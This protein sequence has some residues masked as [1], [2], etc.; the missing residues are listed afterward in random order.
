M[1]KGTDNPSTE[2]DGLKPQNVVQAAKEDIKRR[3]RNEMR[4]CSDKVSD[5]EM[6]AM[7][8]RYGEDYEQ[9]AFLRNH[10]SIADGTFGLIQ[11][12]LDSIT[13]PKNSGKI[14]D[15]IA[16]STKK[17]MRHIYVAALLR[18]ALKMEGKP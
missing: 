15:K 6:K 4:A 7:I 17:S 12:A 14:A 3:A 18:A 11:L 5:R 16:R 2:W 1:E 13:D 10:V 9:Y 8:K